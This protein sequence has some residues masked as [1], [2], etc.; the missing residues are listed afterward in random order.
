MSEVNNRLLELEKENKELKSLLLFFNG[1]YFST[2]QKNKELKKEH[3]IL[4]SSMSKYKNKS[5][6]DSLTGL[7]QKKTFESLVKEHDKSIESYLVVLDIDDFKKIND[8]E[9]H[10][11]G[12]E[13]LITLANII[14]K[15]F[16]DDDLKSRFGG[17]EF[18]LFLKKTNYTNALKLL[19]RLKHNI[20]IESSLP[21]TISIGFTKYDSKL[22]YNKNFNNADEAL[23]QA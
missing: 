3:K 21:F 15:S 5:E 8:T 14:N 1:S 16:R 11:V 7:Y 9:G 4:K 23:Y 12:D 10:L 22:N 6:K 13:M 19:E 18:A 20:L 2:I 17:D